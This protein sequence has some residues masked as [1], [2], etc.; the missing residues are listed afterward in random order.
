MADVQAHAG[1]VRELDQR[2]ELRLG[3]VLRGDEAFLLVPDMLPFG[4]DGLMIVF[5]QRYNPQLCAASRRSGRAEKKLLFVRVFHA[6]LGQRNGR[7]VLPQ[8][9]QIVEAYHIVLLRL[10]SIEAGDGR[11]QDCQ[12]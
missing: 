3:E 1:R 7:A 11:Q 9:L 5:V 8:V 4:L 6:Q 10:L 12:D 2:V